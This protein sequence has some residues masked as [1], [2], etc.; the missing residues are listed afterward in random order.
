M[1]DTSLLRDS[2]F[3][4]RW[5]VHLVVVSLFAIYG[6][7][8]GQTRRPWYVAPAGFLG[9]L[10]LF[11]PV[12][13]PEPA[14]LLLLVTPLLAIASRGVRWM[15]EDRTKSETKS[16]SD[17]RST[18]IAK[19][20]CWS[21]RLSDTLWLMFLF[22]LL[23][24]LTVQLWRLPWLADYN[25]I[26]TRRGLSWPNLA[27]NA[28]CLCAVALTVLVTSRQ[29]SFKR[30][31]GGVAALL[32]VIAA[33]TFAHLQ[34]VKQDWLLI[35]EWSMLVAGSALMS[36][37]PIPTWGEIPLVYLVSFFEFAAIV[38]VG[39]EI[40][41]APAIAVR[42][43]VRS[44]LRALSAG[45]L[46]VLAIGLG[47]V[48]I[49][50]LNRPGWPA[51]QW[52]KNRREELWSILKRQR[53][54]N[55]QD[56]SI[57]DLRASK[58]DETAQAVEELFAELDRLLQGDNITVFDSRYDRPDPNLVASVTSVQ[59]V[60]GAARV[61]HGQAKADWTAGQLERAMQKDLLV[62]RLAMTS[63]RRSL[64]VDTLVGVA[65]EGMTTHH[66][67]E[68]RHDLQCDEIGRVLRQLQQMA[69][70]REP[71]ELLIARDEVYCEE[72]FGWRQRLSEA[73]RRLLRKVPDFEGP[74][75]QCF[76]RR[77]VTRALLQTDLAIRCYEQKHGHWPP[78]L[79]ALVPADLPALPIDA[80]SG[81][82]LVY[83]PGE[84]D[85]VLYS[86]GNGGEDNGGKFGTYLNAMQEGY[87][88][89]LDTWQRPLP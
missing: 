80:Y 71:L 12:E 15:L 32:A 51:E 81:Q 75:Q 47:I 78:D 30:K 34:F 77:D 56:V 3:V 17:S 68:I 89:D 64:M 21:F 59:E 39:L 55:P 53:F 57:D 25:A 29:K 79:Q 54:L 22:G 86:V 33:A 50:I 36:W 23:S 44:L 6:I 73:A 5:Q 42:M 66:L 27:L 74:M 11:L 52:P 1:F 8:W 40:F 48:Y 43:P 61:L 13:A 35:A 20:I 28:F 9:L 41:M 62:L 69:D 16:A 45:L 14:T 19:R 26:S 82:P 2:V 72:A 84:D 58:G 65:C 38:A 46:L 70:S 4:L 49:E 67:G 37:Q 63:Q 10:F 18:N 85:F 7:W 76:A 87:D 60:R 31:M 24:A 88:M 83:R